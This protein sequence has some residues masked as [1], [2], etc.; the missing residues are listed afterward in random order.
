VNVLVVGGAGYIG[1]HTCKHLAQKNHQPIVVDNLSEGHNWAVKWGPFYGTDISNTN[2][3]VEILETEK[4]E[5]VMHFA[6]F[7][8]VA[9]SIEQPLMYYRNNVMGLLSVLTA[10]KQAD[11]KKIIFSG[12]CAVYSSLEKPPFNE[13][14]K[15]GP[16][17]PYGQ[18]KL[19]AEG[20]LQDFVRAH[21]FSATVLRYF[22]ACGADLENEIGEEHNPETHLIPLVLK[23]IHD[24]TFTLSVY[25]DN[26]PTKDGTCIRDYIHVTDLAEAHLLALEKMREKSFSVFNLGTGKG[27]SVKEIIAAAEAVT[28]KKA[29]LKI[30][31]RR[32]GD[33]PELIANAAKS[34]S[35]FGWSAKNSDLK[36]IISSANNWYLKQKKN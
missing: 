27:Y 31:D 33:P 25:G 3:L 23:A 10:M 36:T 30:S 15:T 32:P 19:M 28:G 34:K 26:Y 8:K 11:V 12:T 9:E 18:S 16:M 5:A 2:G 20:L 17:N 7:A 14:K 24:P 35:T 1:S 13:E 22:N 4:I 29:K 21:G 6:A